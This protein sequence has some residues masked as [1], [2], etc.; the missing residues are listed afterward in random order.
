MTTLEKTTSE[1]QEGYSLEQFL[2]PTNREMLEEDE[3]LCVIC[4][5]VP[6]HPMLCREGHLFCRSCILKWLQESKSC[7]CDRESLSTQNLCFN[8]PLHEQLLKM[9]VCC[10]HAA[11]SQVQKKNREA[12]DEDEDDHHTC[13]W[14]GQ[15][16]FLSLHLDECPSQQIECALPGCEWVGPRR[17]L[18]SHDCS[19]KHKKR[20]TRRQRQRKAKLGRKRGLSESTLGSMGFPRSWYAPG[21]STWPS[22]EWSSY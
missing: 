22:L 16:R 15:L 11:S 2:D 13:S 18:P 5:Q 21:F 8:R 14:T 4:F 20:Q 7:P 3:L 17:D 12:D 6:C 10:P 9:L 1:W 19:N